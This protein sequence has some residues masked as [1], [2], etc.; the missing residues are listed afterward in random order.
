M[1]VSVRVERELHVV[2][3]TC[4]PWMPQIVGV[5]FERAVRIV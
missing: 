4:R 3:V 1:Y 2:I 5:H